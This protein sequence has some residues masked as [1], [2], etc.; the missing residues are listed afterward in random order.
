MNKIK[1]KGYADDD[2]LW[3]WPKDKKWGETDGTNMFRNMERTFK[4]HGLPQFTQDY[5]GRIMRKAGT[6]IYTSLLNYNFEQLTG[7]RNK[8]DINHSMTHTV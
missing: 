3:W 2:Q 5:T 6:N 4:H 1:S 7:V 8:F